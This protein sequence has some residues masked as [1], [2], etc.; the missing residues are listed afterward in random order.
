MRINEL[1]TENTQVDEITLGGVGRGLAKGVGAT[2]KGLGGIAGGAAGAWSAAKQGYR[3]AKSAVSGEPQQTTAQQP[4]AT[5][6]TP[7]TPAA[8]PTAPA[9][10][11][12]APQPVASAPKPA[13]APTGN[14]DAIKKTYASLD[15]SE[16]EQLK[17]ELDVIDDQERLATGTAESVSDLAKLAGI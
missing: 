1:I 5:V 10:Q 17:K 6:Q 7:A 15:P 3:A 2:A 14:L 16:R 4:Q 8:K 11:P 12:Q 9:Q 13:A